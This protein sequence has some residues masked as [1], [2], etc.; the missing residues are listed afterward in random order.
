MLQAWL[1]YLAFLLSF[2]L[3]L[4]VGLTFGRLYDA[5]GGPLDRTRGAIPDLP[6][7][8]GHAAVHVGGNQRSGLDRG[9]ANYCQDYTPAKA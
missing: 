4:T 5:L 8:V 6:M 9:L 7:S 1:P 3:G 2:T